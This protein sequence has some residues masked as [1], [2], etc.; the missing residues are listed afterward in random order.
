M[1]VISDITQ[2]RIWTFSV[3]EASIGAGAF[4][5]TGFTTADVF[6][7]LV[8]REI[9]TEGTNLLVKLYKNTAY[10]GGNVITPISRNQRLSSSTFLPNIS[11][12][13]NTAP[14]AALDPDKLIGTLPLK[15][16]NQTPANIIVDNALRIIFL[17]KNTPYLIEIENRSGGVTLVDFSL[18]IKGEQSVTS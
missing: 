15:S 4:Y 18:T 12:L 11:A 6:C 2:G 17:E 13:D 3:L 9:N 10:V 8:N 5:Y 14:A 16:S 7:Q 1:T